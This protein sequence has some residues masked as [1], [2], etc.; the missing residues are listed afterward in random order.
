MKICVIGS[1]AIGITH[2]ET[3]ARHEGFTLA[4]IADPAPGA[5]EIATRHGTSSHADHKSL[6]A[7]EKPD[8]AII[9]A[10]N[11]LHLPIG[12]DFLEA[13]IPVL[14]EKPVA[15]TVAEGMELAEISARTRT[16]VLVGH[17]R[18][19]H[20]AIRKAKELIAEGTLGR[21]AKVSITYDL[22]KPPA[23]FD[24]EWRRTPGVGG[25]L[26]INAIHEID[27]LRFT[28]GEIAEVMALSSSGIRGLAVEDTAA[29]IFRFESGALA[30]LALSDTACGPW[31]WDLGSG[32]A[33]R[34]PKHDIVSH[35]FS[36]TEAGLT[37]PR[38]ELW[39]HQGSRE[40][41]TRMAP[42]AV[43]YDHVDP[44][45]AQLEHFAGVIAGQEAP[46]IDAREGSLN[47]AVM[48]A[49]AASIESGKLS[50]VADHVG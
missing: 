41:T 33:P 30:T 10:P 3:I 29:V 17:H 42:E 13:G 26:L 20:R 37:L 39:R 22:M 14:M 9:A 21:L 44:F 16:P 5:G 35:M 43:T 49:I 27:L 32:D 38:L 40:W 12:R 18:R 2:I 34:F 15:N 6:I 28:V 36:G 50:R 48:Q 1:G 19:H 11:A 7:T 31:S 8:G 46:V 45:V 24:P 4:G 47:L 23:Y 25:P